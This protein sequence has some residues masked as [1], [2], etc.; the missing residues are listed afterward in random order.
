M[1]AFPTLYAAINPP[2]THVDGELDFP[3]ARE[4]RMYIVVYYQGLSGDMLLYLSYDGTA[5]E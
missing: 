5:S 3:A 2:T 4:A 1:P